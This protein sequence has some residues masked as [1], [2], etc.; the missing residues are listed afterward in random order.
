MADLVNEIAELL[1]EQD[2]VIV[3]EFGGFITHY[4]PAV[5]QR[6]RKRIVPPG[7]DLSFNR[8]LRRNDGLLADRLAQSMAITH[9]ASLFLIGEEV[10]Q[11]E[12]ALETTGRLELRGLGLFTR[13]REGRLLFRPM[14]AALTAPAMF[15]LRATAAIP[16][17]K[18]VVE[19][20]TLD[21]E[22]NPV[23]IISI[24]PQAEEEE[25]T[26]IRERQTWYWGAAASAA[27]VVIAGALAL[28]RS[29]VGNGQLAAINPF[30]TVVP[31]IS[32]QDRE[33]VAQMPVDQNV[34]APWKLG[35]EPVLVDITEEGKHS[36][37]VA[38]PVTTRVEIPSAE[39]A[40][41]RAAGNYYVV[42]GCFGVEENAKG[43]VAS[44]LENGRNAM[45][46]DRH[47]GLYRVV[48]G[49]GHSIEASRALLAELK[50]EGAQG[51]WVLR[52]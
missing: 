12:E 43:L 46:L 31:T 10:A 6:D 39:V 5:L 4:R 7:K 16:V 14:Q 40:A 2:C 8:G 24:G 3:P 49:T 30:R 47:K 41:S 11:W 44:Y 33:A 38:E 51:A 20:T 27:L 50:N 17:E 42:V 26:L 35:S 9:P 48:V 13:D 15:G 52:K 25:P 32:Y 29:D 45:V 37:W 34:V 22:R 19:T 23:P 36:H 18:L 1:Y 21:V 28:V